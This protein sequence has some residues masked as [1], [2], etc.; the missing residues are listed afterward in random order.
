MKS[1]LVHLASIAVM[2]HMIFG[3]SW[4]H[5]LS[6]ASG[7]DHTGL[8][9]SCC[10]T[11]ESDSHDDHEH[12]HGDHVAG[13]QSQGE[14]PLPESTFD[15]NGQDSEHNHF[16]CSDDGCNVI[17][18][19]K[20]QFTSFDFLTQYLGGAEDSAILKAASSAFAIDP[21]PDFCSFAPQMRA[22]LLLGVQLI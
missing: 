5:G 18:V 20:Y 22:H 11:S 19:V 10:F 6:A 1:F 7:C 15:H 12:E 2:A 9:S 8:V 13:D 21:F 17:K 16:C 3:C 14:W 4:H